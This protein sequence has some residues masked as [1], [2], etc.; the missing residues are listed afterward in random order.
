MWQII[1]QPPWTKEKV[2]RVVRTQEE[3]KRRVRAMT[4]EGFYV[5]VTK[6][7]G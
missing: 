6:L 5:R 4:E 3:L 1:Y 7:E 2:L